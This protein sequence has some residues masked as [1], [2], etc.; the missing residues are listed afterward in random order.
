MNIDITPYIKEL[1]FEN[2]NLV[3]PGFGALTLKYA[4]STIDHVQG[5]LNPPSKSIEFD[6]NLVVND[7]KLIDII[8]QKHQVSTEEANRQIAKFVSIMKDQLDRREMVNIAGVGRLYKDFEN[9][10]QFIPDSTNFNKEAFGLPTVNFYPILRNKVTADSIVASGTTKGQTYTKKKSFLEWLK[11]YA[12]ENSN[13]SIA[14]ASVFFI[15]LGSFILTQLGVFDTP[16]LADKKVN[17]RPTTLPS[18][19]TALATEDVLDNTPE[20]EDKLDYAEDEAMANT[21]D[22]DIIDT[23]SS[24]LSPNQKIAVVSVGIFGNKNNAQKRIE[25]VYDYGYDALPNKYL[26][27]GREL[28]QIGIQFAFETEEEFNTTMQHIKKKFKDAKV[29]RRE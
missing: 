23:E 1:L 7:G 21:D 3:I 26:K 9:N 29:I 13:F 15:V 24:T 8:Q 14:L 25:Q 5:L 17:E 28:T 10:L 18:Q 20:A 12:T 11:D 27:K 16:P 4:P 6:G 2:N 19:E 22:E